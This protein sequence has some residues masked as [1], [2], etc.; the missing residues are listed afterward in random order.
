L[1]SRF[2]WIVFLLACG[3]AQPV[4]QTSSSSSHWRPSTGDDASARTIRIGADVPWKDAVT[5]IIGDTCADA[6]LVWGDL[7]VDESVQPRAVVIDFDGGKLR[8]WLVCNAYMETFLKLQT[9]NP[10][11]KAGHGGSADLKWRDGKLWLRRRWSAADVALAQLDPP[12]EG[13]FQR[14]EALAALVA[15]DDPSPSPAALLRALAR[16]PRVFVFAMFPLR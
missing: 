8:G 5:Q 4:A 9:M 1:L 6:V 7:V 10:R 16:A 14:G 15:V 11:F 12:P 13:V 2:V 3:G